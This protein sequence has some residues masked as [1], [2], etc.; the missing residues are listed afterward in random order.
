MTSECLNSIC[1]LCWVQ[2]NTWGAQHLFTCAEYSYMQEEDCP[3]SWQCRVMT[4]RSARHNQTTA[5]VAC[6]RISHVYFSGP[7]TLRTPSVLHPSPST[8]RLQWH[9]TAFHD[10]LLCIKGACVLA[11]HLTSRSP[12]ALQVG[13]HLPGY[14]QQE[15]ERQCPG[16]IDVRPDAKLENAHGRT[17]CS[18]SVVQSSC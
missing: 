14:F 8:S 9:P 10:V 3:A 18:K 1:W 12:Q 11:A 13:V 5:C 2:L 16:R 6:A 7:G 17:L 15:N 4:H